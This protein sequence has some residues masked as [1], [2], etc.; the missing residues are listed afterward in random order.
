MDEEMDEDE[1][2]E[3]AFF[4][5]VEYVRV[6]AMLCFNELGKSLLDSRHQSD[7]AVH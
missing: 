3:K 5:V 1:E 4:E 7:S 6:S 2:T